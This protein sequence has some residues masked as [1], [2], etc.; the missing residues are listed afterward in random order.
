MSKKF[1]IQ[2]SGVPEQDAGHAR[3]IIGVVEDTRDIPDCYEDGWK[4]GQIELSSP[5][6]SRRSR[7]SST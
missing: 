6:A 1:H 2:D 3:Y 7:S 4:W 5:T